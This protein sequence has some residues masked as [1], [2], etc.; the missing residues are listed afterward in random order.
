MLQMLFGSTLIFLLFF[1][2]L[3]FSLFYLISALFSL[4]SFT[5]Y[6]TA[7][8]NPLERIPGAAGRRAL[9]GSYTYDVFLPTFGC[10]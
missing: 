5:A 9:R 10:S 1:M 8:L 4:N 2:L 7:T 6:F 3:F